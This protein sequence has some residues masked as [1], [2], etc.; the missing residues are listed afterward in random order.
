M[1]VLMSGCDFESIKV[2]EFLL[3][4][5]ADTSYQ[6]EGLGSALQ[7]FVWQG[8]T[9][10]IDTDGLWVD[11]LNLFIEHGADPNLA[12]EGGTTPLHDAVYGDWGNAT[13]TKFLIDHCANTDAI[14][15]EGNTPLILAC[16]RGE[17]PCVELLL[18]ARAD[19]RIVAKDGSTALS[20]A[21]RHLS[22]REKGGN[23]EELAK[24]QRIVDLLEG[25]SLLRG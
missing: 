5:G 1:F 13:A 14:D 9:D 19:R 25:D 11:C 10:V 7:W 2:L 8:A 22:R 24:A 16:D 17:L 6:L 23:A 21:L 15:D 20:K 4:L 18:G 3:D 12:K